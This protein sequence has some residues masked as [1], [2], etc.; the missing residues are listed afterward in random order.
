[1]SAIWPQP[2]IQLVASQTDIMTI[3]ANIINSNAVI[4]DLFSSEGAY[5]NQQASPESLP[6]ASMDIILESE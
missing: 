2:S 6:V 3:L 5:Y 1:M 4:F